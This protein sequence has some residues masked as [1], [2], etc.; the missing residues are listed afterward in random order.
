MSGG[1]LFETLLSYLMESAEAFPDR[2]TGNNRRYS[3]QDATRAAFGVF[4]CQSPSFLAFQTLMQQQQGKNNLSSLFGAREIPSDNEIRALLDPVQPAL[5]RPVYQRC[6]A[7]MLQEKLLD[8][9][10]SFA[11]SLLLALDATGYFGSESIC[12]P[13]CMVSHHRDGRV[14]YSHAVLLPALVKPETT[15]VLALQPEFLSPQA[16]HDRQDCEYAAAV[17]WIDAYG[18]GLSELGITLLGD[19]LYSRGELV[20]RVVQLEL[21]FIFVVKP[22]SHKYLYEELAGLEKLGELHSLHKRGWTGRAHRNYQYRWVNGVGLSSE[23]DSPRI[24]WVELQILDEQG[25]V[26]FHNAWGTS[27]RISEEN[28][29]ALVEA[30]RCRWKIENE[31]INTLKTKGYHFQH[32]F[33][34]GQQYLSQ[35]LLSLNLIAFLFHTLLELLD[36]RCTLLRSTLP[37][38]DTFFQHISTLTQYLC[39]DSWTHLLLFMLKGLNLSDPDG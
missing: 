35:T 9:M 22:S 38:R 27:H 14:S 36:K 26:T 21:D 34:H 24:N 2:R 30:A 39:F 23:K 15:Q 13:S 28:V 25:K 29:L 5:L 11:N 32:N 20:D 19:D 8:S 33:G 16:G 6:F 12:C 10:R 31:D 17:R 37:R 4:F 1:G 3:L 18:P 7:L